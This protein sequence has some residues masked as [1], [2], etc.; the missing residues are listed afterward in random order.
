MTKT[1][2]NADSHDEMTED[3]ETASTSA[4]SA[5]SELLGIARSGEPIEGG[6]IEEVHEVMEDVTGN[7]LGNVTKECIEINDLHRA[8]ALEEERHRSQEESVHDSTHEKFEKQKSVYQFVEDEKN[9]SQDNISE[10]SALKGAPAESAQLGKDIKGTSHIILE[11]SADGDSGASNSERSKRTSE[12]MKNSCEG[13]DG[14]T[15]ALAQAAD[16]ELG[17]VILDSK[18]RL[19]LTTT[20]SKLQESELLYHEISTSQEVVDAKEPRTTEAYNANIAGISLN[21][22]LEQENRDNRSSLLAYAEEIVS[23]VLTKCVTYLGENDEAFR[24]AELVGRNHCELNA[25]TENAVKKRTISDDHKEELHIPL[26]QSDTTNR[27]TPGDAFEPIVSRQSAFE[28]AI[29]PADH[30]YP[31][32]SRD[33]NHAAVVLPVAAEK[34]RNSNEKLNYAI[35]SEMYDQSVNMDVMDETVTN[36][37]V[38]K[39]ATSDAVAENAK[40]D[41]PLDSTEDE[42]LSQ[43]TKERRDGDASDSASISE[44]LTENAASSEAEPHSS[45]SA[46]K[47]NQEVTD[48]EVT[49]ADQSEEKLEE[50]ERS[51]VALVA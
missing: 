21:S 38:M 37:K 47:E 20:G 26:P 34:E 17:N 22:S 14:N 24:R 3:N 44:A 32:T 11:D 2:A 43:L 7:S 13:T 50:E 30:Q 49:Q 42:G 40:V 29:P 45:V 18:E 16:K 36:N 23:T 12:P 41:V 19:M 10:D 8:H 48:Q 46:A 33:A 4:E 31:V 27:D 9:A 15:E 1:F 25:D 5:D 35:M 28:E 6:S 51:A 39:L